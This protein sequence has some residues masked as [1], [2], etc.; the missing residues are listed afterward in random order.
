MKQRIESLNEFMAQLQIALGVKLS[1]ERLAIY[2]QRLG[3]LSEQRM[4]YAF[5]KAADTFRPEYGRTFPSIAELRQWAGEWH[6]DTETTK[7]I[8]TRDDKP[9][10]WIPLEELRKEIA[11]TNGGFKDFPSDRIEPQKIDMQRVEE[12]RDQ[13]RKL[14]K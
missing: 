2:L 12:L 14:A 11:K 3:A 10:D 6:P 1:E 13:A 8:L 4:Q 9:P 5:E 7:E